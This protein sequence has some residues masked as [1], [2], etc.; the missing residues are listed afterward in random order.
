VELDEA[1]TSAAGARIGG[2]SQASNE[3]DQPT[4][5]ADRDP[6][7]RHN[8]PERRLCVPALVDTETPNRLP[9]RAAN[10]THVKTMTDQTVMCALPSSIAPRVLSQQGARRD[11]HHRRSKRDPDRLAQTQQ[12]GRMDHPF[13]GSARLAEAQGAIFEAYRDGEGSSSLKP[14]NSAFHERCVLPPASTSTPHGDR[15]PAQPSPWAGCAAE[16]RGSPARLS[17]APGW[18]GRGSSH[19]DT[20]R[21]ERRRCLGRGRTEAQSRIR[22]GFR[23]APA[24][25]RSTPSASCLSGCP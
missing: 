15:M 2:S 12:S 25:A 5:V 24:A 10:A 17:R 7:P 20:R 19:R 11:C 1:T 16:E 13:L 18:G 6:G 9:A 3:R 21:T 23:N 14:A 4:A 22:H 8:R